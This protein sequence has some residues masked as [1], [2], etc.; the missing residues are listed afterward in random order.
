MTHVDQ[1]AQFLHP[2]DET[3]MVI[4]AMTDVARHV[5]LSPYTTTC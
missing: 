4:A 3:D 5:L 2:L 1:D